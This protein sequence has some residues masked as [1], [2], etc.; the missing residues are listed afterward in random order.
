MGWEYHRRWLNMRIEILLQ[1]LLVNSAM[2]TLYEE[3]H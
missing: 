3:Q 1:D 2:V